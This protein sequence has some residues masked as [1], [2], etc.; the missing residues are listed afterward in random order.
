MIGYVLSSASDITSEITGAHFIMCQL[1]CFS[2]S[3]AQLIKTTTTTKNS[4]CG[5]SSWMRSSPIDHYSQFQLQ[6]YYQCLS[7]VITHRIQ[8]SLHMRYTIMIVFSKYSIF[9]F[10]SIFLCAFMRRRNDFF[11]SLSIS[12]IYRRIRGNILSL[13]LSLLILT[14]NRIY[15]ETSKLQQNVNVI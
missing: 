10:S 8:L 6:Y 9:L 4:L 2:G 1:G 3:R 15:A 14:Y 5:F 7:L 13:P 11:S 12:T